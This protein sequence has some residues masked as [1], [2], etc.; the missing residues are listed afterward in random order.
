MII[1]GNDK[2]DSLKFL[3]DSNEIKPDPV[4]DPFKNDVRRD[5]RLYPA[6]G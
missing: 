2:Y 6:C 5:L 4:K 1:P 3:R